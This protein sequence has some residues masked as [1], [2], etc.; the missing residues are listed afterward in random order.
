MSSDSTPVKS[1]GCISRASRRR[2]EYDV[3]VAGVDEPGVAVACRWREI[4]DD[5]PIRRDARAP[6]A[7]H[8]A[9]VV[10]GIRLARST[11]PP[12]HHEAADLHFPM[13]VADFRLTR[14]Q[15]L[16]FIEVA[17]DSRAVGT[18]RELEAV[19]KAAFRGH[20]IG[21]MGGAAARAQLTPLVVELLQRGVLSAQL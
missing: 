6:A 17:A 7:L 21:L 14:L 8:R 18:V 11:S 13:N 5:D 9:A 15:M 2:A 10:S 4:A 12:R 3:P 16:P 19:R 20:Q 1:P